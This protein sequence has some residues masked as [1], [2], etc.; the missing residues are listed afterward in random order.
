[1]DPVYYDDANEC[2]VRDYDA[3]DLNAW[4]LVSGDMDDFIFYGDDDRRMSEK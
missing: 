4:F 3:F 1:M 2:R